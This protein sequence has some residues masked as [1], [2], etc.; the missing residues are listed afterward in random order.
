MSNTVRKAGSVGYEQ[1]VAD[2]NEAVPA[3]SPADAIARHGSDDAVFV[4]VRDAPERWEHG[5]IPGAVNASRGM[6]EFHVDPE[7]P[8]H[9]EE[10]DRDAEYVFFCTLG[11]RAS[12]AAQRAG[13][14][15]IERVA[16]IEGG[17]NAWGEADGPVAEAEPRME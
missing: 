17:F 11:A 15:G 16:R 6:L 7:S 13:E 2:A 9:M 5:A 14:M 3:Y 10:F 1:L 12:L 4:D 8:F